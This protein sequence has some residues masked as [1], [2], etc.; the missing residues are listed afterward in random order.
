MRQRPVSSS[1]LET[2]FKAVNLVINRVHIRFEDDCLSQPG[3][4]AFGLVCDVP[5]PDLMPS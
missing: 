4:M 5:K 1:Y 2:A 3:T